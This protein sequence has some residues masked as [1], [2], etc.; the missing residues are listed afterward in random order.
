MFVADARRASETV[1]T[2]RNAA[3]KR[4]DHGE[5]VLKVGFSDADS[6]SKSLRHIHALQRNGQG[7]PVSLNVLNFKDLKL[8]QRQ[9]NNTKKSKWRW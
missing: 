7:K 3:L 2:G 1:I 8:R 4:E 5:K 9:N 6:R